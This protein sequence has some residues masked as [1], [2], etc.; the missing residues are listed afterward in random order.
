MRF[1][2]SWLSSELALPTRIWCRRRDR[3]RLKAF[4]YRLGGSRGSSAIERRA[5]HHRDGIM[6]GIL[7]GC[8]A[9]SLGRLVTLI[10]RGCALYALSSPGWA[11]RS[12][13]QGTSWFCKAAIGDRAEIGARS[14]SEVSFAKTFDEALSAGR[15]G[16]IDPA[17]AA[18]AMDRQRGKPGSP[19]LSFELAR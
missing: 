2:L 3:Q 11:A 14:R 7:G 4:I 17:H 12:G 10:S 16:E 13:R 8:A 6:R 1:A 18:A 9:L 19:R 15:Q 5:N